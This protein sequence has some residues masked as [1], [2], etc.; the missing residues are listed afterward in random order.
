[1]NSY[2]QSN[3]P[4]TKHLSFF[5]TVLFL[6]Q[7]AQTFHTLICPLL[8]KFIFLFFGIPVF[9]FFSKRFIGIPSILY[10]YKWI[11][12]TRWPQIPKKIR[13]PYSFLEWVPPLPLLFF[14]FS[15]YYWL[16]HMIDVSL[17]SYFSLPNLC[18]FIWNDCVVLRVCL[19]RISLNDGWVLFSLFGFLLM[20]YWFWKLEFWVVWNI[21]FFFFFGHEFC[22]ELKPKSQLDWL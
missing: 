16:F 22:D 2:S 10:I 21:H 12:K 14:F 7:P 13:T 5:Y 8:S 19:W 11:K 18:S 1:M 3:R 4:P 9:S 15:L 20:G 6:T 17:I